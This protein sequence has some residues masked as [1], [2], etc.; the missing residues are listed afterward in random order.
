MWMSKVL[1]R[2]SPSRP[3]SFGLCCHCPAEGNGKLPWT[4]LDTSEGRANRTA[5]GGD[6]DKEC[7]SKA[8]GWRGKRWSYCEW[9]GGGAVRGAGAGTPQ[10][11]NLGTVR[12]GA[13]SISCGQTCVTGVGDVSGAQDTGLGEDVLASGRVHVQMLTPRR[14][15]ASPRQGT[16][17]RRGP[18]PSTGGFS[19]EF[20]A[21]ASTRAPVSLCTALVLSG[22]SQLPGDTLLCDLP[23]NAFP[24][25]NS[26]GFLLV[27]LFA[28]EFCFVLFCCLKMYL[29][30][31]WS[32][33]N[34]V[35]PR[36]FMKYYSVCWGKLEMVYLQIIYV[37]KSNKSLGENIILFS[38]TSIS[39][40]PFLFIYVVPWKWELLGKGTDFI[41]VSKVKFY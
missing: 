8:C 25:S 23:A 20:K 14:L 6:K 41:Q 17:A 33:N 21:Q 32:K 29:T 12:S 27:F 37:N 34:R 15:D 31:K 35:E 18:R 7:G 2:L 10:G 38:L 39:Q 1:C 30:G 5:K 13:S 36:K 19:D 28:C 11:F 24:E 26:E 40:G 4:G 9:D 22:A 16:D 3:P